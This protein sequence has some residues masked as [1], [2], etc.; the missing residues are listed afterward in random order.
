MQLQFGQVLE[1]IAA[2]V[3]AQQLLYEVELVGLLQDYQLGEVKVAVQVVL[4]GGNLGQHVQE[5]PNGGLSDLGQ[6]NQALPLG[7]Q[8]VHESIGQA[9]GRNL[10]HFGR[11][12]LEAESNMIGKLMINDYQ[13]IGS[14]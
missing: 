10:A 13:Q 3:V 14:Y 12:E 9:D 5:I 7:E 1:H 11:V 2:L 8:R 4:E 6:V